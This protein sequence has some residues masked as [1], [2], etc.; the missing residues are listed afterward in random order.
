MTVFIIVF[1]M[2]HGDYGPQGGGGGGRSVSDRC[3][4]PRS[5]FSGPVASRRSR[6]QEAVLGNGNKIR[7]QNEVDGMDGCHYLNLFCLES[8]CQQNAALCVSCPSVPPFQR[9]LLPNAGFQTSLRVLK[10]CLR[11]CD[12]HC[13]VERP[14][15]FGSGGPIQPLDIT[16]HH[17]TDI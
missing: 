17:Q 14:V 5:S 8:Q 16:R 2:P 15:T 7:G 4:V 10:V 11:L 3:S 12:E 6:A 1:T 13:P 9:C